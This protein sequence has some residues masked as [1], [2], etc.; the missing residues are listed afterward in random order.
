MWIGPKYSSV[1][2]FLMTRCLDTVRQL[3]AMTVNLFPETSLGS[4]SAS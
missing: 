1:I 3:I 4:S 2:K